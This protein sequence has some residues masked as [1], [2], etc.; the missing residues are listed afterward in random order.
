[1]AFYNLEN[2]TRIQF[3]HPE[4]RKIENQAFSFNKKLSQKLTIEFFFCIM[5]GSSFDTGSF[6]GIK[7][8][9]QILFQRSNISFIPESSFKSVLNHENSNVRFEYSY[10][11]CFDCKNHWMIRDQKDKQVNNEK[12]NH[13]TNSTLFSPQIRLKF[14]TNCKIKIRKLYD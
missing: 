6:D 9:T 3:F 1:M 7:R 8:P 12:C 5:N 2:L 10:L 11:N 14:N 13:N 4:I